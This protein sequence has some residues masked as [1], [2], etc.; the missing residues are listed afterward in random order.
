MLLPNSRK[1]GPG[2]S[3]YPAARKEP[4]VNK[5]GGFIT[6]AMWARGLSLG[7]GLKQSGAGKRGKTDPFWNRTL[8]L[9]SLSAGGL[10]A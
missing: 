6:G 10:G 5:Q 1:P 8:V 3:A 7:H 9:N 4:I 2:S